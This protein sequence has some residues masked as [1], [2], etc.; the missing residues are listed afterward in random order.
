MI[1]KNIKLFKIDLRKKYRSIRENMPADVKKAMDKKILNNFIFLSKYKESK[2]VFTYVSKDIEVDTFGIMQKCWEDGK[3]VA[4][5]RCDTK[6][7]AMDFYIIKSMNDL[8]SGTFGVLEPIT[9][10]CEKATDFSEGICI[11]PGFCFDTE[12][13][14]LGYGH[15]YYDRFLPK[16]KDTTV[17]FCY[18]N[19]LR[20]KLPHGKFDRS[21]D[22]LITDK[23]IRQFNP[24]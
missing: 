24:A 5:P 10:Q 11:V 7:R 13:Y 12:G 15:G 17:G 23:Y 1:I 3:T 8:Q 22:I 19:C 4:V 21:V 14:R 6:N 2:M 18:S 20:N 16:I 9:S